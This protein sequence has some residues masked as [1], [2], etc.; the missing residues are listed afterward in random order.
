MQADLALIG[1]E[2]ESACCIGM[3]MPPVGACEQT[4]LTSY[5]IANFM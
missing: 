5:G 3:L 1:A 4:L 2:T